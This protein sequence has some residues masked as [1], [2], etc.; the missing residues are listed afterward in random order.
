MMTSFSSHNFFMAVQLTEAIEYLDLK[1]KI[2][3]EAI[4]KC[5]NP[6]SFYILQKSKNVF[7][8]FYDSTIAGQ[9]ADLRSILTEIELL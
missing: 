4:L 3:E 8:D 5:L 6:D 2:I 9:I 1:I 7:T